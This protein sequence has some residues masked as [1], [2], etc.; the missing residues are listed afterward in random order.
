MS[1]CVSQCDSRLRMSRFLYGQSGHSWS[2]PSCSFMCLVKSPLFLKHFLQFRWTQQWV[3]NV[4][5]LIRC[6]F[7]LL[8]NA[9]SWS[10]LAHLKR[11][12]LCEYWCLARD[13]GLLNALEHSSQYKIL[14]FYWWCRV[15]S[16]FELHTASHILHPI[17]QGFL[18]V[19]KL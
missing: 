6:V 2:T 17:L 9:N 10:Q 8:S 14:C 7:K 15:S 16:L 12:S 19:F 18:L 4:L 3:A 13:E 1:V 5:W 11:G